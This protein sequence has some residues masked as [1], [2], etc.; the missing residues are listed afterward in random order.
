MPPTTSNDGRRGRLRA[1]EVRKAISVHGR[2]AMSTGLFRIHNSPENAR[3]SEP[4]QEGRLST[5]EAPKA[6]DS[7]G[8]TAGIFGRGK[9]Y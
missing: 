5:G 3:G 7:G 1:V 4:G 2:E 8:F 6:T 9:S